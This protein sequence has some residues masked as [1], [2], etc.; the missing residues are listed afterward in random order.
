LVLIL[1]AACGATQGPRSST[2]GARPTEAFRA[3]HAEIKNKLD[4]AAANAMALSSATP[5]EV[6]DLYHRIVHF[7]HYELIPH[8]V[9]EERVLYAAADRLV[10]TA[11]GR[12]YTD[13]LRYEH[14]AIARQVQ[15]LHD[16][17]QRDDRSPEAIDEFQRRALELVGLIDAH[18]GVEENVVLTV[19]D[20]QMSAEEFDR[21]VVQ[22]MHAESGGADHHHGERAHD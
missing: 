3:H 15:A 12:R 14:T 20:E 13:A 19:F 2:D 10:P 17:M 21:E 9:A 16:A 22:P 8:A 11:H 1:L 7:F 5:E 6:G 18:F 4:D